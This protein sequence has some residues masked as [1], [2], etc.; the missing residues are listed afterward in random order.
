[1]Y[2][3][4]GRAVR[5]LELG[6]LPAGTYRAKEKAA[7]WDG[8]DSFGAPA[9]SGVYFAR[10]QAGSFSETRRMVLLK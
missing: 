2:N 9:A 5:V 4:A 1:M 6:E 10:I 8:R 3:A 7:F